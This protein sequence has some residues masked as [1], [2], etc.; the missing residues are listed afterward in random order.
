MGTRLH[1]VPFIIISVYKCT[2]SSSYTLLKHTT[3]MEMKMC[4]YKTLSQLSMGN[5]GA[6]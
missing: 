4:S 5:Q 6:P 2:T 1:R 3:E